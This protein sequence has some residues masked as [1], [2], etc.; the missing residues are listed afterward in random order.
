MDEYKFT[1]IVSQYY[2][3]YHY[4]IVEFDKNTF[5]DNMRALTIDLD[6]YKGGGENSRHAVTE[7]DPFYYEKSEKIYRRYNVNGNGDIYFLNFAYVNTVQQEIQKMIRESRYA[8]QGFKKRA[9]IEA[10]GKCHS[11]NDV[12]KIIQKHFKIV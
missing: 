3:D 7:S 10:I 6:R 1:L 5:F 8:R 4:F 9:V 2:H 11:Y 12:A